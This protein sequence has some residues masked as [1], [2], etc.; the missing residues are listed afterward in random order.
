M[1]TERDF[2]NPERVE[3]KQSPS[4]AFFALSTWLRLPEAEREQPPPSELSDNNLRELF[5]EDAPF[6]R[7]TMLIAASHVGNDLPA[8]E[9]VSFIGGAPAGYVRMQGFATFDQTVATL[10][11]R[12]AEVVKSASEPQP[13]PE[14]EPQKAAPSV[15]TEASVGR[16]AIR[17]A[18]TQMPRNGRRMAKPVG[19]QAAG[20]TTSPRTRRPR[21]EPKPEPELPKKEPEVT[22]MTEEFAD[23]DIELV[24]VDDLLAQEFEELTRDDEQIEDESTSKE[25]GGFVWD[26]EEN[27]LLREARKAAEEERTADSVRAYLR[28][29]GRT[30]LLNAAEEVELAKRVEAGLFAKEKLNGGDKI[31][32]QLHRDLRQLVRRGENAKN[33]LLKANLRLVVSIAKKKTGRGMAFL[34]LIQEGNVG[35]IRAVEK[36]DYTRGYKFS[37]YATWWIKQAITRAMADQARTIRIP[38]HMVEQINKLGRIQRELLQDL[39]REPTPEE[40]AKEMDLSPEKVIE[41]QMYAREPTSLDQQVGDEGD[42]FLGDFIEDVNAPVAVDLVSWTLLQDQLNAVLATLSEREAGVIR[43]RFGLDDGQPRTLDEI[44][45]VFGVTRERIRQI[46][47]KTMSKLRHPSRSQSLRDYLD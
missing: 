2:D 26:E 33:H 10:K 14:L 38:V 8:N 4:K 12:V 13:E 19:S 32:S 24:E 5:G 25:E 47:S 27:D 7:R 20:G 11:A 17:S 30:P 36:F 3:N 22:A 18:G 42:S 37:T 34:D 35:L 46:E 1:S 31:P 16:G 39:G 21:A 23:A 40:L 9:V 45:Q 28:E 15:A 43:L 41:I 6:D 29:I 44:G